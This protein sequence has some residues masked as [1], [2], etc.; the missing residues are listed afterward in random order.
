MLSITFLTS[1]ILFIL[2]STASTQQTNEDK[3]LTQKYDFR[4]D[5]PYA[6]GRIFSLSTTSPTLNQIKKR[7]ELQP[8]I[9]ELGKVFRT[10][11]NVFEDR[12]ENG[13]NNACNLNRD[14]LWNVISRQ[15]AFTRQ[16][17]IFDD[18][19]SNQLEANSAVAT[20]ELPEQ[21]VAQV[22]QKAIDGRRA[23]FR[24]IS[25][26][27]QIPDN[28]RKEL[29][30]SKGPFEMANWDLRRGT[31]T[32]SL[33]RVSAYIVNSTIY[34]IAEITNNPVQEIVADPERQLITEFVSTE[35]NESLKMITPKAIFEEIGNGNVTPGKNETSTTLFERHSN[36]VA[37]A[38]VGNMGFSDNPSLKYAVRETAVQIDLAEDA[39]TVS[40]IAI[41]ALPMVM[42]FIPV[43]FIAELSTCAT[44]W[45][46]VFTDIFSAIPFV[47]KGVELIIAANPNTEVI[48]VYRSGN[49]T[50]GQLEIWIGSC[51][52]TDYLRAIGISFVT[53]G[54]FSIIFA[55]L[56]ELYANIYMKRKR[57]K[58][59]MQAAGPFGMALFQKM[60]GS[61]FTVDHDEEFYDYKYTQERERRY[62]AEEPL[63]R[64]DAPEFEYQQRR[65]TTREHRWRRGRRN[66]NNNNNDDDY[67]YED[68][69][70]SES[71]QPN[72]YDLSK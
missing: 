61:V 24:A 49:S 71:S 54:L 19:C 57:I 17:A 20:K 9:K 23:L 31:L 46:V 59:G 60:S 22:K 6:V 38:S 62:S 55:S 4:E 58:L 65:R 15:I 14:D 13:T 34:L 25:Q 10:F 12:I 40:N 29:F 2:F 41:L 52:G 26:I 50:A 42:S 43:A 32:C 27:S 68:V 36:F 1:L 30:W 39:I 11:N 45:Y 8:P 63:Y 64:D 56:L 69:E 3:N 37:L 70:F 48:T 51:T 72:S 7:S 35:L 5:N 16:I 33:D 21:F 67:D 66:N 18:S 28:S 44:L 53:L 47:V